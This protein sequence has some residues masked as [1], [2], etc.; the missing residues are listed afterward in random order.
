MLAKAASGKLMTKPIREK[1]F[2]VQQSEVGTKTKKQHPK[3]FKKY[4]P[5]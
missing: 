1:A 5:L 2:Y 3:S 4:L